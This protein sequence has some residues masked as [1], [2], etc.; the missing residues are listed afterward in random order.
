MSDRP[1][2]EP[3]FPLLATL[4]LGAGPPIPV[5]SP[6]GSYFLALQDQQT[7]VAAADRPY[8][9]YLSLYAIP[10]ADRPAFLQALAFWLNSLSYRRPIVPVPV[11]NDP[12]TGEPALVR[13]NLFDFEWDAGSRKKRIAQLQALG[14][15]FNKG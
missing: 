3:V 8:I 1:Q 13:V 5:A 7:A 11:V 6:S 14:V 10:A 12:E 2:D 4:A 15:K 9:R